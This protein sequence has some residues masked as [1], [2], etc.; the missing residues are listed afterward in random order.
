LFIS[1]IV[2]GFN[3]S[4]GQRDNAIPVKRVV[5]PLSNSGK[6]PR[7]TLT[8]VNKGCQRNSSALLRPVI[9]RLSRIKALLDS[10]ATAPEHRPYSPNSNSRGKAM[11]QQIAANS[12]RRTR[13]LRCFRA[14]FGGGERHRRCDCRN[15]MGN[16][17][18]QNPKS[19]PAPLEI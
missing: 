19:G 12:D 10:R 18:A 7:D 15:R 5:T 4:S 11:G 14:A 3:R 13:D 8:C 16:P 9:A 2:G 6:Q 17:D 1:T